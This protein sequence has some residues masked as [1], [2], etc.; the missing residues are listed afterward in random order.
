MESL[1]KKERK[2]EI[3][4]HKLALLILKSFF[5]QLYR[6]QIHCSLADL[7]WYKG[8][9]STYF[10][11]YLWNSH[12]IIDLQLNGYHLYELYIFVTSR[13]EKSKSICLTYHKHVLQIQYLQPNITENI[14]DLVKKHIMYSLSMKQNE[15]CA[16]LRKQS[17]KW[18]MLG[19]NLCIK[20]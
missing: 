9:V 6:D 18:E 16:K 15:L 5:S 7:R 2:K 20:K 11:Y 13:H 17:T 10:V 19:M 3:A 14:S 8:L 12:P 1:K 4:S